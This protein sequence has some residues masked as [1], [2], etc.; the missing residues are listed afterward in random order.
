MPT[1]NIMCVPISVGTHDIQNIS[2]SS[3]LPGQVRVTGDFIEGSTA[4]GLLVV[5]SY[6][7]DDSNLRYYQGRREVIVHGLPQGEY[8]ISVFAIEEDGL[9]FARAAT[10]SRKTSVIGGSK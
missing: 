6:P 8:G 1:H 10:M 7:S 2:V 4:I 3:P 9:P 5:L